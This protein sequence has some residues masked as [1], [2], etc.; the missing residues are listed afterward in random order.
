MARKK[1]RDKTS[2]APPE[3]DGE[4]T[5]FDPEMPEAPPGFMGMLMGGG[6]GRP[7]PQMEREPSIAMLRE[8]MA[9]YS[10]ESEPF[11]PGTFVRLKSP[12][13]SVFQ[14]ADAPAMFLCYLDKPIWGNE[15]TAQDPDSMT[16]ATRYDCVIVRELHGRVARH[17]YDSRDWERDPD[18]T[19]GSH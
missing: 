8:W 16:A 15:V 5:R 1:D 10:A 11:T 17:Q 18:T 7:C 9:R 6:H 2:S 4:E 13:Q 12:K 3:D 14:H 19:A